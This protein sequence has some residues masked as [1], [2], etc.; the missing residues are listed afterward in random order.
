MHY[1]LKAAFQFLSSPL[2]MPCTINHHHRNHHCHQC[3]QE[4]P[5]LLGKSTVEGDRVKRDFWGKRP[6]LTSTTFFGV[7]V[8][9]CVCARVCK[10]VHLTLQ[11]SVCDGDDY[12][13]ERSKSF[14]DVW[15]WVKSIVASSK[16][17]KEL[18]YCSTATDHHNM[19]M[20]RIK[21][22]A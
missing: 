20:I 6:Q 15:P 8:C 12:E 5:Y 16:L 1:S 19:A 3:R 11:A 10:C 22:M 2:P 18:H 4:D 14:W 7:F 9:V 21:V 17:C 13:D